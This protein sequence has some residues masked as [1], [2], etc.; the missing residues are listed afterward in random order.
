M[1]TITTLGR[2]KIAIIASI[3]IVIV[4]G[5]AYYIHQQNTHL[6]GKYTATFN[7]LIAEGKDTLEF[8]GDK[9]KEFDESG[10]LTNT[11]TYKITNNQIEVT[12]NNYKMTGNLSDDRKTITV[13]HM[14]NSL[15]LGE[16][17]K[18]IK[19]T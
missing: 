12:I 18:Y 5:V 13:T 1:E 9:V 11:G 10:E 16:G 7:M 2:K 14:D 6:S 4:V 15:G 17:A 3:A 19:N 8:N